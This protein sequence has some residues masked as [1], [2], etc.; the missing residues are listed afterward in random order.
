MS[1]ALA[2][3]LQSLQV[4]PHIRRMLIPQIAVLLQ[5]FVDDRFQSGRNVLIQLHRRYWFVTQNGPAYFA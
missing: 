1:S 2:I 4:R 3:A 5:R